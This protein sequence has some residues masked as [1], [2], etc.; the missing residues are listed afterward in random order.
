MKR[1]WEEGGAGGNQ[2][3]GKGKGMDG[4]VKERKEG[5]G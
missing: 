4:K 5:G 3:G 1:K 2:E